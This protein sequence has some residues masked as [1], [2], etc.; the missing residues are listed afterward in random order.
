MTKTLNERTVNGVT[1]KYFS[2][3]DS[4]F[5]K[6]NSDFFLS[7]NVSDELKVSANNAG[8]G[9]LIGE[10]MLTPLNTIEA[11]K[12]TVFTLTDKH[13]DV[14]TLVLL[15]LNNEVVSVKGTREAQFPGYVYQLITKTLK[16]S[17]KE[18][19][20][21]SV[22]EHLDDVR[23]SEYLSLYVSP[24]TVDDN[25]LW[26][27]DNTPVPFNSVIKM[28]GIE[29]L[30]L[31]EGLIKDILDS[32]LVVAVELD[33]AESVGLFNHLGD[34]KYIMSDGSYMDHMT[35]TSIEDKADPVNLS[36]LR[37]ESEFD[38]AYYQ[39]KML[40][41]RVNTYLRNHPKTDEKTKSEA[42]KSIIHSRDEAIERAVEEDMEDYVLPAY[43]LAAKSLVA[44]LLFELD[45]VEVKIK[46]EN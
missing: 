12:M 4:N 2:Y 8:L 46:G 42:I 14:L 31:N 15:E 23:Y 11:D 7:V 28:T 37:E 13:M 43:T 39:S 26:F 32:G 44:K 6:F 45:L 36:K 35:Y 18:I 38:A 20:E 33:L 19:E 34:V 1:H 17:I 16:D 25:G 21:S 24:K 40:N 10:L 30:E 27:K 3:D 22:L 41:N 9:G 5:G 29:K